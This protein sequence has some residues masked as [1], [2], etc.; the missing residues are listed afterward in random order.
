MTNF[1][2]PLALVGFEQIWFI[3]D[4]QN[5]SSCNPGGYLPV[6]L[7]MHS[8]L[9]ENWEKK[10]LHWFVLVH[11]LALWNICN[12]RFILDANVNVTGLFSERMFHRSWAQVNCCDL[13][14]ANLWRHD[15]YRIHICRK[16]KPGFTRIYW[17]I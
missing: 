14:V 9:I 8:L 17:I 1:V 2:D 4:H 12:V 7:I 10:I 6:I 11:Q 5:W 3:G 13:F 16:F 15:S